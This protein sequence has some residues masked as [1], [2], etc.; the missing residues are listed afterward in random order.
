MTNIEV[1]GPEPQ[2]PPQTAPNPT[3]NPAQPGQSD[4]KPADKP[5]VAK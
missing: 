2:K 4:Q 5:G 1:S 3:P